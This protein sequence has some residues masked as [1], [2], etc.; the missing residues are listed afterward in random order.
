MGVRFLLVYDIIL[1]LE[2]P[3]PMFFVV[4]EDFCWHQKNW[5]SCCWGC[6]VP[7][8]IRG[9]WEVES[10]VACFWIW[11]SSN[12]GSFYCWWVSQVR[13]LIFFPNLLYFFWLILVAFYIG[14]FLSAYFLG[15]YGPDG[16]GTNGL[17]KA[18]LAAAKSW[19]AGIPV[20]A[21]LTSYATWN[22]YISWTLRWRPWIKVRT[23]FNQG[24]K[25][26]WC[27]GTWR[28]NLNL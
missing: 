8:T 7:A 6:D 26:L 28:L 16:R 24:F 18:I 2:L 4:D 20:I 1:A 21:I 19:A 23:I 5:T 12:R 14:W 17:Q 13:M 10:W 15:G 3:V 22:L 11:N 27:T 25:F 9:Y